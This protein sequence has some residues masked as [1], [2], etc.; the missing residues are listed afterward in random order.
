[1]DQYVVIVA[2]GSGKRMG[3]AI[4]KQFMELGGQP[5]LMHTIGAFY[6]FNPAMQIIV[7]L[8]KEQMYTWNSLVEKNA[9][10]IPHQVAHGGETRF[11]SVKN[12]L[13]LIQGDGVVGIHD[14]VRPFV[15]LE[16]LQ[17]CYDTAAREGSAIPVILPVDSLRLLQENGHVMLARDKVRL[18]QTPQVFLSKL[19]KGAY[20][21]AFT[22]DFTDDA[23]VMEKM[24][25]ELQL[26]E[27]N[28]ENIKITDPVDWRI[29]QFILEK[30]L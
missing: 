12:G 27:G 8:P 2:G 21:Q 16:T 20:E 5:L 29:A 15:S 23:T 22:P 10:Y 24:G 6:R 30:G 25:H 13:Q 14:G 18:V 7:V 19:L 4:P 11:H 9:F 1:M 17:R 3:S 26:V 28:R